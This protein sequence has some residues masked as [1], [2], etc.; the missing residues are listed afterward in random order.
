MERWSG[1]LK[2]PVST[3]SAA[4]C[5]VAASLCVSPHSKDLT[6]PSAN[7]IF[8]PGDQVQGT[9]NPVI[10]R[11][12]DLQTIADI[13]VSKFG[14]S[15]N[16]W[17]IE[18]SNFNGPFAVYKEFVPSVNCSGEPRSYDPNGFPASTSIS[19]VL[20]KFLEEWEKTVAVKERCHSDLA[21]AC[22]HL[23]ETYVLGFSKGGTVVNQLFSE[24][25]A[26]VVASTGKMGNQIIP[27]SRESLLGSI[28]QIHY[29]DVGLNTSGAYLTDDSVMKKVGERVMQRQKGLLVA[30][31][32][33]PRQWSDTRRDWICRE[34]DICARLL[35]TEARRTVGKLQ[36]CERFYFPD[37]SPDLQMHF[38]IIEKL[39]ISF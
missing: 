20:S 37:K 13:L 38:E 29:V 11:L 31:H 28:A 16:A 19:A 23:P 14:A 4:Q 35:E 21:A 18:A 12:S 26:S 39:D 8:F 25:G 32:G 30:L 27:C 7:A 10:E 5:R 17:V 1:I 9:G 22:S 24:L 36:V 2:V 33:T 34:K 6:V 3:K 15:V